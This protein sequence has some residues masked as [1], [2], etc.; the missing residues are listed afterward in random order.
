M[1]TACFLCARQGSKCSARLNFI[2]ILTK[3]LRGRDYCHS[4]LQTQRLRGSVTC[5]GTEQVHGR[6]DASLTD[7]QLP[8]V[9]CDSRPLVS[10]GAVPGPPAD[11]KIH[12][13]SR[14]VGSPRSM[15]SDTES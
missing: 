12:R 7:V 4:R 1:F 13:C 2:L 10:T 11:A 3:T 5:R 15:P 9:W 8:S 6:L 14:P